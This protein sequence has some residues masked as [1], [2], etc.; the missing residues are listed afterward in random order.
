MAGTGSTFHAHALKLHMCRSQFNPN[1]SKSAHAQRLCM[2]TSKF[3]PNLSKI[4]HAQKQ[5]NPRL[6]LILK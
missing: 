2:C 1:F 6:F 3:N 4:A 5:F